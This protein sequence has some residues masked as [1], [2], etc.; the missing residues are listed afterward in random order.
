LTNFLTRT[1]SPELVSLRQEL[2]R[3]PELSGEEGETAIRIA[4]ELERCRPDEILRGLGSH[5]VA[6]IYDSGVEGPTVLFRCELDGLPITEIS[7][8]G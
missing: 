8:F 3:R 2:H 4:A 5:G 6:A 1:A 7:T